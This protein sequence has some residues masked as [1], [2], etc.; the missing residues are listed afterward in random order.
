[1][2]GTVNISRGIWQD[3]AFKDEP[4][5]ER[6][7]FMWMIM[8]ASYKPREK[9]V[10]SAVVHTE[11]GQLATSVRFMAEAWNWSKSRVD[12]FLK[13]LENRDM[14]GTESGTGIN[15]I[16]ICKYDEYQAPVISGGTPKE[17]KRDS[18]GTPPGQ[19]R[20]KPKKGLLPDARRILGGGD[21]AREARSEMASPE[22]Q[23]FRERLLEAI[24]ADP[25]TGLTGPAGRLIGTQA[26]MAEAKRWLELPGL[27]EDVI[28]E[29]VRSIAN[30]RRSGK[31]PGTFRY[32]TDAMQ[33]LSGALTA[34]AL[35]PEAPS[36][37]G[38]SEHRSSHRQASQQAIIEAAARGST[39]EREWG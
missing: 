8:E 18:S 36:T 39:N 23:T 37:H 16:T 28:V 27:T 34:P 4:F 1:M 19:Q 33:R 9:R 30:K 38:A 20:D 35:L 14:I 11:R 3:T 5:T 13:R 22:T 25:I 17:E 15:V 31:L 2:A 32:F 7:A 12:R 24:G 6:E 29:E 21:G 10:G 26:D